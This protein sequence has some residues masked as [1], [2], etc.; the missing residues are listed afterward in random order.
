MQESYRR[1]GASLSLCK[2]VEFDS[3]SDAIT[4]DIPV[5]GITIKGWEITPQMLPEVSS[6]VAVYTT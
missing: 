1:S 4:L 3:E 2:L 5:E 6:Y